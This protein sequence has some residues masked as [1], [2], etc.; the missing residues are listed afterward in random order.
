MV[1]IED[2]L[3]SDDVFEKQF[4]CNLKACKGACC[5]EGD[6]GAPLEDT[7]KEILDNIYEDIKSFLTPA[8]RKVIE[9]EGKYTYYEGKGANEWGTPL[10][11]GSACAYMTLENGTAKC[12]IEA[13][14]NAG[15]TDFKKPISCH[16]YPIRVSAN[17][18]TGFE[19]LNYDQW[20]IC[21]AA[22]ELGK[23]EEVPVY[24]F[25]KES[26]IR[27]YG[28]DFYE[29]MEGAAGYL[30]DEREKESKQ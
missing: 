7:E 13:A 5:W 15:A 17:K 22:C 21:S 8:G 25:L 14:Y 23:K 12:G 16:L 29:Q 19:A 28:V 1:I 26:I 30:E 18:Q 11:E 6:Y 24:Q 20:E 4:I 27:K 2:K 9:E 10:L 3:V